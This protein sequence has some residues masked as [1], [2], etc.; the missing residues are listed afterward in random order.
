[1]QL[2]VEN[3]LMIAQEL[4]LPRLRAKL[5]TTGGHRETEETNEKKGP[6]NDFLR[7]SVFSVVKSL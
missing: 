3:F 6:V 1:M 4:G 7:A 5:L 2:T